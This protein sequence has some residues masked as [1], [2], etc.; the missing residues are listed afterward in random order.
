MTYSEKKDQFCDRLLRRII[1]FLVVAAFA[2]PLLTPQVFAASAV[3]IS[4]GDQVKGGETF[5]VTVTYSGS[6]IGS[7]NGSMTY[8]T[9]KLNYLSG[10]SSSGNTGY[11]Q[12]RE[13]GSGSISFQIKFQAVGDGSTTLHVTTSE[14]YDVNDAALDTPS[15]SKTVKVIG[16]ASADDVISETQPEVDQTAD[17]TETL[18]SGVD[19]KGD[20]GEMTGGLL[21]LIISAAVLAVLIAVIATVL[22]RKKRKNGKQSG[23]AKLSV[24]KSGEDVDSGSRAKPGMQKNTAM[25]DTV[26]FQ[27]ER[28]EGLIDDRLNG[29][30]DEVQQSGYTEPDYADEWDPNPQED[31]Q[32]RYEH[33]FDETQVLQPDRDQTHDKELV[34]RHTRMFRKE[35]FEQELSSWENQEDRW[36]DD[37]KW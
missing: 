9:N 18:A 1:V 29:G 15:A 27:P 19:E 6:Q 24:A 35:E 14:M 25:E 8:D 22:L 36:P 23:A 32:E 34:S 33:S 4:G 3:S 12:L 37:D 16:S 7:V 17:D 5:T 28:R 11:I 31:L 13:M 2:I 26:F 21:F 30:L 20:E 10:G